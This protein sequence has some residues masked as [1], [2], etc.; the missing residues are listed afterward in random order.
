M[1]CLKIASALIVAAL[2]ASA[3][4]DAQS[5]TATLTYPPNGAVNADMSLPFQWTTV[6][7]AQWYYLYVGT[8]PGAKDLIDSAGLHG[9]SFQA[10]SLPSGRTIYVRLWTAVDD[11][12]RYVD[13]TFTVAV[14]VIPRLI[15]PADGAVAA[16]MTQPITWTSVANPEWYYLYV[17]TTPGAKDLVDTGGVHTTSYLATGLPSGRT[18]YARIWSAVGGIWQYRDSTFTAAPGIVSSLAPTFVY[19]SNGA[20]NVSQAQAFQWTSVPNAQWYY[21][22]VGTRPGAQDLVDTG[23]IH[24]TSFLVG[25]L[26]SGQTLYARIWAE[27]GGVWRFNDLTFTAAP[28]PPLAPTLTY[29]ANGAVNVDITR[30]FTWTSVPNAQAYY[31]YVGT[32]VGAHDIVDSFGVQTTSFTANDYMQLKLTSGITLYARVWAEVGGIWRYTDSTFIAAP[33]PLAAVITSPP[34]LSTNA[35]FSQPIQWTNIAGAQA[36]H[37]QIG[38]HSFVGSNDVL[39]NWLGGTS[40]L[41][42]GVP[43]G[44]QLSAT[45]GTLSGGVWRYTY[46][47][48]RAAVSPFAATITSPLTSASQPIQWTAIANAQGYELFVGTRPGASDLLDTGILQ[49]TSFPAAN[50]PLS[51]TLF[52]RLWTQVNGIWRSS[53]RSFILSLAEATIT[54]PPNGTTDA[55]IA[56]PIQWNRPL[57][58]SAFELYLGTTVGANDLVDSGQITTQSYQAAG[59][60]FGQTIYARL[61]MRISGANGVWNDTDS[62]FT[63]RPR[64]AQDVTIGFGGL[65]VDNQPVTSYTES[66]FAVS[67]SGAFLDGFTHVGSPA[68]SLT[69][70]PVSD[71]SQGQIQIVDTGGGTFTLKSVD[72]SAPWMGSPYA[73]RGFRQ[74]AQVFNTSGTILGTNGNFKTLVNPHPTDLIDT[75]LILTGPPYGTARQLGV[76][77]IVLS[78]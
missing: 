27:V 12:W 55:D 29:P 68:P 14:P 18:L 1:S 32:A 46:S 62:T 57:L 44:L 65:T 75:L 13:T 74:G 58:A 70:V 21:L 22:Y 59:L 37:L 31:L 56:L 35:D 4:A 47:T 34:N 66:G 17:G 15:Y 5:L 73:I 28:A 48:F 16:D 54:Y 63:V 42:T 10:S 25:G 49:T 78:R 24:A 3:D 2:V 19:P 41:A 53:D 76:D 36:Y 52:A 77:N 33:S 51:V 67:T 23:G 8:T 71:Q 72:F 45:L 26:P 61:R 11:I 40:F 60:P 7:N 43:I 69:F 6:A 30:P 9:T 20:V 64:T 39:D 38:S 50:L